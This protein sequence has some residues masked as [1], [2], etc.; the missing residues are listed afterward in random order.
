MTATVI[1]W[2]QDAGRAYEWFGQSSETIATIERAG[3]T[4]VASVV[5]PAGPSGPAGATAVS[6]EAGN[7]AERRM[8]GIYVPPVAEGVAPSFTLIFENALV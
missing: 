5:G 1:E 6:R 4:A 7:R 8:D 3:V 2:F